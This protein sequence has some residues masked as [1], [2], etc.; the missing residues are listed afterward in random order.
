M[1]ATNSHKTRVVLSDPGELISAVPLVLG[2]HP[3]DSLVVVGL[4]DKDGITFSLTL[5]ADLPPRAEHGALAD[6]LVIPLLMNDSAGAILIVVRGTGTDPAQAMPHRDLVS[7]CSARFTSRGVPVLHKLW[8]ASMT[9]GA[10][11][12]CYDDPES[13]GTVPDTHDS[14]ISDAC[15]AAGLVVYDRREDL[16]AILAPVP[17]DLLARR[18]DLLSAAYLPGGHPSISGRAG[19]ELVETWVDR[20]MSRNLPLSDEDIVR[21]TVALSDHAVRDA[22]LEL[23]SPAR[24][25]AG[26]HLWT[27]LVRNTPAPERAEAASLLAFAAYRRGDGVFAA[28]AIECALDADPSHRL[29]GLV[30]AALSVG[31]P[32]GNM[33]H[34]ATRAAIAA[35]SQLAGTA[36]EVPE[37]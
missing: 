17:D 36:S 23:G 7:E 35:R 34:A 10:D 2:I 30:D 32:P 6:R 22:C 29:S 3:V 27:T 13:T 14:P 15:A 1:D 37:Q 8:T 26:E 33:R 31:L 18:A 25:A 16:A 19:L 4:D 21:V 12:R 11:W 20:A 9:A 24:E 28:I 5:R